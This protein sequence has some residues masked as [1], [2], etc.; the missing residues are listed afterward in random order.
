MDSQWFSIENRVPS[1][2]EYVEWESWL[3]VSGKGI[4][5]RSGGFRTQSGGNAVG[6]S[7]WCKAIE[8]PSVDDDDGSANY[9]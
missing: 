6:V 5:S 1:H 8:V 7:R 3:G 4:Y 2:G 9:E